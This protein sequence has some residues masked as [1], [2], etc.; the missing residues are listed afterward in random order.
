MLGQI[1]RVRVITERA[2]GFEAGDYGACDS[3]KKLISIVAGRS[4]GNDQDTLIH[5]IFHAVAF[6]MNVEDVGTQSSE[7][8]WIQAFATGWLAVL[9]DNPGLVSYLRGK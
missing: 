1:Y 4:L 8:R 5:E 7:E 6:E 9:K 3:D 2:T